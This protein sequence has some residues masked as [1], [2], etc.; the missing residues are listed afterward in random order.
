[1]A[2][3]P[4]RKKNQVILVKLETTYDTDSVPTVSAN[5]ILAYDI[6]FKENVDPVRRLAQVASLSRLA[7]VDG[8]KFSELSFKV[9]LKGSG[10]A[11]TAPR[12]GAILRACSFSEAVVSNT[13]V[14]YLPRSASQESVTVYFLI[15]G[16]QHA[17]TGCVGDVKI[18]CEAG[19]F[20]YLE[21]T[22]KGR[23]VAPTLVALTSP[24]LE[25]TVPYV[26]KFVNFQY[27]SKNTLV[28]KSTLIEMNNVIAERTSISDANDIAGFLVT[29]RDPMVTIDPEAIIETSYAF[30]TDAFTNYR[31]LS[32]VIGAV[33]GNI[34]TFSIPKYNPYFPEYEDRDE[35]LVEK[36]KGEASQNAGNDEVSIAFT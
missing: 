12:I 29:G 5:S 13:S 25:S 18:N 3:T 33:A 16:R 14:T 26:C 30:R 21:V 36:I 4:M 23:Y 1:M 31:T 34:A 9:E 24:T 15:D 19:Q 27:N 7:S 8:K 10:T 28:L 35:I 11:G 32:W 22:L 20:A 17:M 2:T 6:K